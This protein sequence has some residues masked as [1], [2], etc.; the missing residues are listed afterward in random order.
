MSRECRT[1]FYLFLEEI[2]TF[3]C[4]SIVK[5]QW[6]ERKPLCYCRY[7]GTLNIN[8][9]CSVF[10]SRGTTA[11]R[12]CPVKSIAQSMAFEVLIYL[13]SVFGSRMLAKHFCHTFLRCRMLGH[14]HR[15][16]SSSSSSLL[17]S[18]SF[19]PAHSVFFSSLLYARG[20]EKKRTRKEQENEKQCVGWTKSHVL[21]WK[22]KQRDRKRKEMQNI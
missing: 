17:R 20:H 6:N 22:N 4:N 2:I 1:R 12:L 15:Q 8:N 16:A 18:S 21:N 7:S 19:S 14:T 3:L 9:L 10:I 5:A 11:T 13:L